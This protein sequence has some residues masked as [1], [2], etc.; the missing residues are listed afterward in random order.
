MQRVTADYSDKVTKILDDS[1]QA[2]KESPDEDA[3]RLSND[4]E[5]LKAMTAQT[6][7]SVAEDERL[8]SD[9]RNYSCEE[10]TKNDELVRLQSKLDERQQER[11]ERRLELEEELASLKSIYNDK[12]SNMANDQEEKET[13]LN[14]ELESKSQV[15]QAEYVEF[16]E[17]RDTL[18]QQQKDEKRRHAKEESRL[19]TSI[20]TLKQSIQQL[21]SEHELTKTTKQT[22]IKSLQSD[23]EQQNVRRTHLVEHFEMVDANN[24]KKLKEQEKLNLVSSLSCRYVCRCLIL[25]LLNFGYVLLLY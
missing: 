9:T 8:R 24:A 2:L 5:S 3:N 25:I 4:L 13:H 15:F 20:S 1:I 16:Q 18:L 10:S 11:K 17:K 22:S 21:T 6:K 19:Q 7:L 12:L 23:I 14:A